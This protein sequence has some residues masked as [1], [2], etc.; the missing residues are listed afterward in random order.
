MGT[1]G[2]CRRAARAP[3]LSLGLLAATSIAR[4]EETTT[5]EAAATAPSAEPSSP[6][7]VAYDRAIRAYAAGDKVT[8][9]AEMQKSYRLSHYPDLLY[10]IARLERELNGCRAS[11][12]HYEEYLRV[13]PSGSYAESSTTAVA[14]LS[15]ECGDAPK[16]QVPASPDAPYWNTTRIIGWSAIGAAAATGAAALAFQLSAQASASDYENVERSLQ[17]HGGTWDASSGEAQKDAADRAVTAA[18]ILGVSTGVLLAGGVTLLTVFSNQHESVPPPRVSFSVD[19]R[20][21]FIGYSRQF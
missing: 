9:L 21:G 18:R 17:R 6:A 20:G 19:P 7:E 15:K 3:A 11:L 16:K 8:A 10:N 12:A 14:Q 13:A 5:N 2:W 1:L 4:A